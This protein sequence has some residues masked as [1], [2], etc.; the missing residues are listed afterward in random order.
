MANIWRQAG[1]H[2]GMLP[3]PLLPLPHAS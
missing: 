3:Y 1:V 2:G